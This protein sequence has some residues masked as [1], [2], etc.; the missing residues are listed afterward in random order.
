MDKINIDAIWTYLR[1]LMG[2]FLVLW[3][4]LNEI[5]SRA[6]AAGLGGGGPGAGGGG[7]ANINERT[8]EECWSTLQRVS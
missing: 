7:M 2:Y 5:Q 1:S 4:A 6:T 3:A 8:L